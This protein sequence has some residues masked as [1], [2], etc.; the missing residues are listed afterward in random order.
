MT[1]NRMMKRIKSKTHLWTTVGMIFGI[2]ITYF[3]QVR[4]Q[5]G[6]KAGMIFIGLQLGA[7]FMRELTKTSVDEK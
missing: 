7:Y 6:A 1:V 5:L 3:D 4:E 2:C